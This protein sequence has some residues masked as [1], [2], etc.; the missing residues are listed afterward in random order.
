MTDGAA[1]ISKRFVKLVPPVAYRAGEIV[2][3]QK[4]RTQKFS[5]DISFKISSSKEPYGLGIW[6]INS[7]KPL[8]DS[9]GSLFGFKGDYAG[10]GIFVY[11]DVNGNWIIHGNINKGMQEYQLTP[12]SVSNDNACTILG[13]VQDTARTIR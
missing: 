2:L 11:K 9:K 1:V 10:L 8:K 13:N 4:I 12:E 3:R 7:K 5:A 6:Y